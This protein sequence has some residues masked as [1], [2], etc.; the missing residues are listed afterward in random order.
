M[1]QFLLKHVT[2]LVTNVQKR[3]LKKWIFLNVAHLLRNQYLWRLLRATVHV[4]AAKW[5]RHYICHS[6]RVR[7]VNVVVTCLRCVFH[8]L[9]CR[10]VRS[11]HR[12][13]AVGL[14]AASCR[15]EL[16][17]TVRA[18]LVR[19]CVVGTTLLDH[20]LCMFGPQQSASVRGSLQR[21]FSATLHVARWQE[22]STVTHAM[23]S[24]SLLRQT[25]TLRWRLL[26]SVAV[27]PAVM[28]QRR[29]RMSRYIPCLWSFRTVNWKRFW[30]SSAFVWNGWVVLYCSFGFCYLRYIQSTLHQLCFRQS[31]TVT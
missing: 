13:R 17:L 26:Y 29:L 6:Q 4:V 1:V 9:S 27:M 24:S 2:Q 20:G 14:T 5:R 21:T 10:P 18:L 8:W 31:F 12:R 25:P 7:I 30:S 23:R 16:V 11:V 3:W 19:S 15:W 22:R 28:Q